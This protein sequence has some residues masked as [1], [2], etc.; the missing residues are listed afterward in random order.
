V[1]QTIA[2]ENADENRE[3]RVYRAVEGD[4][5]NRPRRRG[6]RGIHMDR[7]ALVAQP[8]QKTA[9]HINPGNIRLI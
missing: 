1:G 3:M 8:A 7:Y 5:G 6:S 2:A 4:R 9:T